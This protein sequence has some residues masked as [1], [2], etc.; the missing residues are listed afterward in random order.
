MLNKKGNEMSKVTNL[1]KATEIVKSMEGQAK[2]AVLEK[3]VA[4]LS[5]TRSNAF[6]YFTKASKLLGG[7]EVIKGEK[8]RKESSAKG[9]KKLSDIEKFILSVKAQGQ[10]SPFQQLVK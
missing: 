10:A 5:I 7:V 4:E 3:L 6:V 1:S 9:E 2:A 8:V